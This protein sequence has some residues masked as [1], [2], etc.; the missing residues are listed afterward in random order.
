MTS[1]ADL[2]S[3]VPVMDKILGYLNVKERVRCKGVCRS[4]RQEIER[5]EQKKNDTLVLHFGPYPS[6]MHWKLTNN[7]GLMKFENSLEVKTTTFLK[8]PMTRSLL[9]KIKK[10]AIV[11]FSLAL[12]TSV[13]AN[14][15]GNIRTFLGYFKQC[16]ELELK[17]FLFFEGALT[18]DLPKLK[19]LM[20]DGASKKL[21]LNCPSLEVLFWTHQVQ[22]IDFQNVK[23][24][25]RL[26]CFSWPAT[27]SLKGK[28]SSLVYFNLFVAED[29]TIMSDRL[30]ELM[31]KLKRFVIYSRDPEAELEIIRQQQK[32]YG[33]AD[34]EVLFSGFR[35]PVR[36]GLNG[37]FNG[38][39]IMDDCIELHKNYSKLV[40]NSP[41]KIRIDYSKLFSKFK[42]LPS[43]F[44]ERF[45]ESY[46]IEIYKVTS[47]IHLLGFLKNYPFIQHLSLSFSKVDADRVLDLVYSLQPSLPELTIV[48]ERSSDVLQIDLSFMSLFN[49]LA[50]LQLRS[51]C[52]PI[53]FLRKV[54]SRRGPHL[55]MFLFQE[56]TTCH[57]LQVY[58][59]S[60]GVSLSDLTCGFQTPVYSLEQLISIAQSDPHLRTF[61]M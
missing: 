40:E 38:M 52:I 25:K 48:E 59:H 18:F 36:I 43:D 49:M 20:I 57:S 53:Q 58:F 61:F 12:R 47:Y 44:F 29:G 23:K 11:K 56:F 15:E 4:W 45:D 28:F 17:R 9:E 22:E 1:Y 30:L 26:I 7:G 34:L 32:L 16:E 41:W 24:L 14:F 54:T 60:T 33:P 8:H 5:R 42:I 10:L 37:R 19:V 51:T 39:V 21:V 55:E 2:P 13:V 50:T 3:L 35:D 46:A 31:P 27:V 6:N